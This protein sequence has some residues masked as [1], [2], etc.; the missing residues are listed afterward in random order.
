MR[1]TG[2][3]SAWG[4]IQAA[5]RMLA[6]FRTGRQRGFSPHAEAGEQALGSRKPG[7]RLWPPAP[8]PRPVFFPLQQRCPW[9]VANNLYPDPGMFKVENHNQK[10][11]PAP[12]PGSGSAASA[13]W[14]GNNKRTRSTSGSP[15]RTT[16]LTL[17]IR[18]LATLLRTHFEPCVE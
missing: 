15:P 6:V 17:V 16:Q 5:C 10:F 18:H 1:P 7:C 4:A 11:P 12:G 9:P 2:G 14:L 8:H 13:L 3:H